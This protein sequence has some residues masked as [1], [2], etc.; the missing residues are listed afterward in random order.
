MRH[1]AR[2]LIV[3][4]TGMLAGVSA[5]LASRG[6]SVGVIARPGARL[7]RLGRLAGVTP[8]P[9]D[10]DQD[11]SLDRA[12]QQAREDG[13]IELVICWIHGRVPNGAQ[14][15]ARSSGASR[16]LLVCGS[17]STRSPDSGASG[18]WPPGCEVTRVILG[19]VREADQSRWLTHV[20]IV[21]GVLDAVDAGIPGPDRVVGMIAPWA[22]RPGEA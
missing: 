3:G 18:D 10:W 13:S 8:Y 19:F 22:L 12:V 4:G 16:F 2:V 21:A 7:T 1:D 15:V 17:G 14:R 11:D 6:H 9:A 5:A 20:E